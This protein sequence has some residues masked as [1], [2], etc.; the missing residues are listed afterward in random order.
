VHKNP[1]AA[2]I[3]KIM[4]LSIKQKIIHKKNSARIPT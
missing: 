3:N 4:V 2:V 1:R